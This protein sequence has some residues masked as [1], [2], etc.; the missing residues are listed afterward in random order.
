MYDPLIRDIENKWLYLY[1]LVMAIT[2]EFIIEPSIKYS[3]T[4]DAK[5]ISN[6]N[7]YSILIINHS[8]I[9]LILAK[10]NITAKNIDKIVDM[11][12]YNN[13]DFIIGIDEHIL[14]I[15]VDFGHKILS[16]VIN[17]NDIIIPR[18]KYIVTN[19]PGDALKYAYLFRTLGLEININ[20]WRHV[21]SI[22]DNEFHISLKTPIYW[23]SYC[24]YL[25]GIS[26]NN[27]TI[28]HRKA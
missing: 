8:A 3:Y 15:Y 9:P 18:K 11:L 22:N 4:K 1:S 26:A 28:Y 13:V 17:D 24:I 19:S 27:I 2:S 10:L 21:Y 20:N 25:I 5:L 6:Y 14:K 16:M 23:K 12:K 7:R